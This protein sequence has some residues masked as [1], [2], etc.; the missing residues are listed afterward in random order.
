[1]TTS[2]V[3]ISPQRWLK[4]YSNGNAIIKDFQKVADKIITIHIILR[5]KVVHRIDS[6]AKWRCLT[7]Q[8]AINKR[9]MS[10]SQLTRGKIDTFI[11]GTAL[12]NQCS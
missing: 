2:S 8:R 12:V 9:S 5:K 6:S 4:H 7:S 10:H 1:M 3:A 11:V